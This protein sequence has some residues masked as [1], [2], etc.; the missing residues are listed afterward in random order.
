M[1]ALFDVGVI[2]GNMAVSRGLHG[3]TS[4]RKKKFGTSARGVG[5]YPFV[6]RRPAAEEML[7]KSNLGFAPPSHPAR[8]SIPVAAATR[9]ETA[10]P[11]LIT[12]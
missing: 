12:F 10:K 7:D 9:S 3:M 4:R 8:G 1:A 2:C 11:A 6:L 5:F